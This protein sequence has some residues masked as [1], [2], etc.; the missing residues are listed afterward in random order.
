MIVYGKIVI[1]ETVLCA[2]MGLQSIGW[3]MHEIW[4]FCDLLIFLNDICSFY[5]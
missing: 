5:F 2:Y 3:F 1:Y 4:I